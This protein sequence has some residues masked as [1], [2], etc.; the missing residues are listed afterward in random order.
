MGRGGGGRCSGGGGDDCRIATDF[1]V[2]GDDAGDCGGEGRGLGRCTDGAA[3]TSGNEIEVG[4]REVR[5]TGKTSVK[6]LGMNGTAAG[7]CSAGP[8]CASPGSGYARL[9]NSNKYRATLDQV[10]PRRSYLRVG[11]TR[12]LGPLPRV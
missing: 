7:L 5:A 4:I 6:L 12:V 2:E 9:I 11:I 3:V 1:V 8:G 10:S